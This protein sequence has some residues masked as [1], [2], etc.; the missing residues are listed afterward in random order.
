MMIQIEKENVLPPSMN[1]ESLRVEKAGHLK[2]VEENSLHPPLPHLKE[3]LPPIVIEENNHP[4]TEEDN[5]RQIEEKHVR[6][7]HENSHRQI[8]EEDLRYKEEAYH[9]IEQEGVH[10][11][12]NKEEG[13]HQR[14][15]IE[16][17]H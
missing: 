15:V 12:N 3:T 2:E 16:G 7:H 11:N 6:L 10:H 4:Q 13:D 17:N 8:E 14:T 5:H 1:P 9:L